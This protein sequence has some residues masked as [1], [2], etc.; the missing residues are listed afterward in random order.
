MLHEFLWRGLPDTVWQ[1][2]LHAP[3]FS[4]NGG[5]SHLLLCDKTLQNGVKQPTA[6]THDSASLLPRSYTYS[7][8]SL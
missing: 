3:L 5:T 4:P 6:L 8:P 2:Q 1:W 7:K